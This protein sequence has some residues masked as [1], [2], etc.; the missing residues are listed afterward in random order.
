[1]RSPLSAFDRT[2]I[3]STAHGREAFVQISVDRRAHG[4]ARDHR[5]SSSN[6]VQLGARLYWNSPLIDAAV[7]F[8]DSRRSAAIC[9]PKAA[10]IS[11]EF[12]S[13]SSL[14]TAKPAKRTAKLDSSGA[15]C[16]CAGSNHER[17]FQF[18]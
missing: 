2:G 12:I 7:R 16:Y 10:W 3:R 13:L 4:V 18:R 9:G 15:P 11:G 17:V 8:A 1:A 5:L 14:R 6:R